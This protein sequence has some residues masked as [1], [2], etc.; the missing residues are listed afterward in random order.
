MDNSIKKAIKDSVKDLKMNIVVLKIL[1][2][3]FMN[4]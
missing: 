2:N 3:T 1:E 4:Q